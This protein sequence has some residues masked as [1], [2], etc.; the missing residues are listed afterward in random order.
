MTVII[1]KRDHV[2]VVSRVVEMRL[3]ET[4]L[5]LVMAGTA[6]DITIDP[7]EVVKIEVIL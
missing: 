3:E 1:T 2:S 7:E 5:F 6:S 4:E